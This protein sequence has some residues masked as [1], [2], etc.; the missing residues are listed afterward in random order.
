MFVIGLTGGIGTGKSEVSKILREMGAETIS[1]DKVAHEVYS[2][3]SDGLREVVEEFGEEVLTESGD[4]DR[5]KLGEIVFKD[6]RALRRLNAIV[7]PRTRLL[8]E[9]RM[10]QLRARCVGTVVIEV[11]LLAEAI[12]QDAGWTSTLDEVWVTVAPAAMV[13]ERLRD[14][15]G[16]DEE[17]VKARVRSQVAQQERLS[18]ADAVIDNRGS[19][20][21][22]RQ[23]VQ[24]LWRQRIPSP[25]KYQQH[26]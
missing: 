25:G 2:R 9:E 5:A 14:R 15:D 8:I 3:G 1:A 11:P 4:V 6:R 13:V 10:H 24:A 22:L 23:Q 26:T 17:A 21:E 19:L 7:H 12:R 20:A 16:L 18:Y